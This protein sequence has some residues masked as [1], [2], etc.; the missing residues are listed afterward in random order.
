MQSCLPFWEHRGDPRYLPTTTFPFGP[1][2][3]FFP[4]TPELL[5]ILFPPGKPVPLHPHGCHPS[6]TLGRSQCTGFKPVFQF[7]SSLCFFLVIQDS[8]A[9]TKKRQE[10][11]KVI[12]SDHGKLLYQLS[13]KYQDAKDEDGAHTGNTSR[14]Y[15]MQYIPN[16]PSR[17]FLRSRK[18]VHT[19][20]D[21]GKELAVP[22]C[23]GKPTNLRQ[24][25]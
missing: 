23:K 1:Q 8:T 4:S 14:I 5:L 24:A 12:R 7:S 10:S 19:H 21:A 22:G 16:E 11:I 2:N 13:P 15:S 3:Q 6:L 9:G 18:Y 25:K 17:M 20:M